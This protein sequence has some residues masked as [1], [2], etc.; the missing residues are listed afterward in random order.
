MKSSTSTTPL[1][2]YL[3]CTQPTSQCLAPT[4]RK[5]TN[6]PSVIKIKSDTSDIPELSGTCRNSTPH[7]H[8]C[9]LYSPHR[10]T[11]IQI[12]DFVHHPVQTRNPV[13]HD[14]GPYF[15]DLIRSD[16]LN[17]SSTD[18]YFCK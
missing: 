10:H 1:Y 2:F 4:F 18:E 8:R 5:D 13:A 16:F 17:F 9:L 12:N 15:I 6:R 7:F 3:V 14:W 11:V